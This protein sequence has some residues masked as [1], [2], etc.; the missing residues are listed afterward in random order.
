MASAQLLKALVEE[1]PL[2][3]RLRLQSRDHFFTGPEDPLLT[4]ALQSVRPFPAAPLARVQA[5][6]AEAAGELEMRSP[7]RNPWL[8]DAL[9]LRNLWIAGQHGRRA[10]ELLGRVPQRQQLTAEARRAIQAELEVL[11]QALRALEEPAAAVATGDAVPVPDEPPVVPATETGPR[12]EEH[13]HQAA[14]APATGSVE[15]GPAAV[16]AAAGEA[17]A[18]VLPAAEQ[19][20]QLGPPGP[21]AVR[22]LP[23]REAARAA[24]LNLISTYQ[25]FCAAKKALPPVSKLH[26]QA[27]WPAARALWHRDAGSKEKELLCLN[28]ALLRSGK[29]TLAAL[30][31]VSLEDFLAELAATAPAAAERPGCPKCRHARAGCPPSCLRRREEAAE[32]KRRR[33]AAAAPAPPAALALPYEEAES[34]AEME[35]GLALGA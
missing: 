27:R 20:L 6:F 12:P 4:A 33:L 9:C 7:D 2:E 8:A 25:I 24:G 32:K 35:P 13:E 17:A 31:H 22:A 15:Q 14:V 23:C 1:V 29:D 26:P 5:W 34:E 10:R 18:V 28:L 3:T 21:E 30:P 16:P 11:Q 19:Q